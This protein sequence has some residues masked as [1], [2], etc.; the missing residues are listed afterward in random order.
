VADYLDAVSRSSLPVRWE[1]VAALLVVFFLV[2]YLLYRRAVT[3]FRAQ[4]YIVGDSATALEKRWGS[5]L[6]FS[7]FAYAA[8]IFVLAL[9]AGGHALHSF[10]GRTSRNRTCVRRA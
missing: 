1:A 8:A 4:S 9:Y 6:P 2:S 5:M 3:M 10:G 7:Q